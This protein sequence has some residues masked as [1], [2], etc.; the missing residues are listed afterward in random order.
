M[1]K[2]SS[3]EYIVIDMFTLT[4]VLTKLGVLVAHFAWH[5]A[6]SRAGGCL[7]LTVP[8]ASLAS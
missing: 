5:L 2:G 7:T 1:V 6:E 3:A 4:N 8:I